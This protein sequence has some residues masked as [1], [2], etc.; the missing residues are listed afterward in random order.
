MSKNLPNLI[1]QDSSTVN[2]AINPADF[3]NFIDN[4]YLTYEPGATFISKSPDGSAVDIF[5]VTRDTKVID[6]VTCTVV[7]DLVT[8]D[9][10]LTEKTFDYFAQDK[11]GNVWYFGEDAQQI[12]NGHVVGTEGSWRAGVNGATPGIIMEAHPQVGD[13][14]DQENAVGVAQDHAQVLSLSESSTVP[15]GSFDHLLKTAETSLVEPGALEYKLYAAGVGAISAVDAVTGDTSLLVQIKVDGTNQGDT[16]FGYAG[17]DQISGNGGNDS[18]D[19]RDGIDTVYGGSG[20]D[21][22][23]GG[24]DTVGDHL[25][26]GSGNDRLLVRTAD[27]AV[28]GS[29]DD[30]IRLFDNSGFGSIDGGDQ[31]GQDLRVHQGDVLQFDGSLDL[32]QP[33]VS[34]R[35]H[36]IETLSMKDG[37]SGGSLTLNVNDVLDLGDGTFAPTIQGEHAPGKGAALRVNGDSGDQLTL[38]GTFWNAIDASNAPHDYHAYASQSP[39]GNVYVL[40]HDD[41]TVTLT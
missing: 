20:N 22:L 2:A 26:G 30:T 19:G 17:P 10:Q 7:K 14:Y 34:A 28:G 13:Q 12:V 25:D 33:G 23:D 1:P 36:G 15:Y 35:I 40:V 31:R 24:N 6:G 11:A 37:H 16:L 29:G 8:Q 9:G 38:N 41:V 4:P 5:E 39:G 18:L 21:T 27:Q 3:V 32:T